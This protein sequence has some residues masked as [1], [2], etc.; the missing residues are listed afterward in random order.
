MLSNFIKNNNLSCN[1]CKN[2][3]GTSCKRKVYCIVKYGHGLV[4]YENEKETSVILEDEKPYSEC[5]YKTTRV[6]RGNK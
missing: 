5:K 2:R 1:S 6:K 4:L 3:K